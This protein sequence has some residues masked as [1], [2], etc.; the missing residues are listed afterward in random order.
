M[1]CDLLL[2]IILAHCE[3]PAWLVLRADTFLLAAGQPDHSVH[4]CC[5]QHSGGRSVT[6]P[7]HITEQEWHGACSEATAALE[8]A[9]TCINDA[10]EEIRYEEAEDGLM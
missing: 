7:S 3:N 9:V 5:H 1:Q 10:L 8:H 6:D 2:L 4:S